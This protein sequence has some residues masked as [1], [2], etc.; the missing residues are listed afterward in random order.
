M[1][2]WKWEALVASTV[3]VLTAELTGGSWPNRITAV[4]LF[5]SF[6]H[7]QVS[8]RMAEG[9]AMMA[10]PI[11]CYRHA[12]RY[13]V[14]K[15]VSWITVFILAELWAA[16]AGSLTFLAY[17]AWRKWYRTRYPKDLKQQEV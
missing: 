16:I 5:F 15:E 8:D 9:Q 13:W 4:A 2:T 7:G 10:N 6:M 3:F 17:P 1:R 14:A 11:S 12:G